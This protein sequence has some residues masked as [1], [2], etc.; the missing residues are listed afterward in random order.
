DSPCGAAGARI[1]GQVGDARCVPALAE[2]ALLRG[3]AAAGARQA[4]VCLPGPEVAAAVRGLAASGN[5]ALRRLAAE[6]LAERLREGSLPDLVAL[7]ADPDRAVSRRAWDTIG[8]FAAGALV[9]DLVNRWATLPPGNRD[10][11]LGALAQI[12]RRTGAAG[13][14]ADGLLRVAGPGSGL[15]GEVLGNLY[16]LP[17]DQADAALR[18]ALGSADPALLEAA[19]R[20]L[21]KWRS[22]PPVQAVAALRQA[23][24][25]PAPE[26]VKTVLAKA[27]EHLTALAARNLCEGRPVTSSHPWQGQWAPELAVDGVIAITSY[28]SCAVSPSALTVDLGEALRV[29]AVR[30]VNYWDGKRF[31][32]Y[33]VELSGDGTAWTRVADWSHNTAPAT[34]EGILHRFEPRPARHVRVTMLRNSANP[35]MHVVE[36]QAFSDVP[37]PE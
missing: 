18:D 7:G 24:A 26:A 10:D 11:A 32:Q 21:L 2:L 14:I 30:V 34:G 36:V 5:P 16:R 23:L 35:G 22:S 17:C 3:E 4:L 33:T 8:D 12:A 31:Y 13:T 37:E 19:G 1:L 9:P 29:A 28:W 6:L 15:H 20:G 27:L 25:S